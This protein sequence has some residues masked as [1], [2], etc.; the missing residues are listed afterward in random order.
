MGC[1]FAYLYVNAVHNLPLDIFYRNNK[2]LI[3]QPNQCM[4]KRRTLVIP[5][6]VDRN[7]AV[8]QIT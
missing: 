2:L 7:E 4:V 3:S 5:S 8:K 6:T 1:F